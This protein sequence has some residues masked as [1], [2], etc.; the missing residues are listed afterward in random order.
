MKKIFTIKDQKQES[1]LFFSRAI[2]AFSVIGLIFFLMAIRLGYLQLLQHEKYITLAEN[3]RVKLMPIAPNRGLIYDRNGILLAENL[4][5]YSL[6]ITP[7]K[8][9]DIPSTIDALSQLVT[10][11]E[12]DKKEFYDTLKTK[13]RFQGVPIRLQLTE[14]ELARFSV[15]RHKFPGVEINARLIRHYLYPEL[16]G[17]S[18]GYVGRINEQ[19]MNYIDKSNYSATQHIGKVGVEKEYEDVLHGTVGYQQIE[20]NAGGRIVRVL[21]HHPPKAGNNLYLAIDIKLQEAAQRALGEKKGAVVAIEPST[22]E[23]LAFVST[24]AFDPNLFVQGISHTNYQTLRNDPQRPLF[25]RALVATYP[26]ASTVKPLLGIYGLENHYITPHNSY[27]CPGAFSLPNSKRRYRDWRR[28]GD[29]NLNEAIAE[30]CDVYFYKLSMNMGINNMAKAFQQF[31]YGKPTG[32]DLPAESSGLVPTPEWKER[33]QKEPW[34]PGETVIVSIGQGQMLTTPLQLAHAT[35]TLANEGKRMQ[36]RV[37]K[38][39]KNDQIVYDTPPVVIEEIPVRDPANWEAVKKGMINVVHA[40]YGT[41]RGIGHNS[42]YLIAGKTG[43]AQVFSLNG[44]TYNEKNLAKHLRDHKLFIAYAPADDPQ[45]ALAVFVENDIG[46]TQIAR[47]VL[48][49]Y[50][51]G[52]NSMTE[53]EELEKKEEMETEEEIEN[54]P[55]L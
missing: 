1:R 32:I 15:Q 26:P 6:E 45:I 40:P 8:I 18:I 55:S 11:T 46:Q 31:G 41:A 14:E 13:R 21:E 39:I 43:T 36:P 52:K 54:A 27:Y 20:L 2:T 42:P 50:I 28:H 49:F 12:D 10:I 9:D 53:K 3:N 37:V 17:H 29:V 22:G 24:P 38:Q 7:E 51:L 23:V 25:N 4:P 44:A 35:S 5:A 33:T 48:D 34:Y 30:S 47:D 19:E 16:T